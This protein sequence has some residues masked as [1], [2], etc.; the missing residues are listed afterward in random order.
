MMR[1][2]IHDGDAVGQVLD[3]AEIVGDEKVGEVELRAQV[4][5]QV[6]DLRLDRH[7][8]RCDRFVA[9]QHVGLHRERAGDADAL[10]L[11]A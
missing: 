6:Q 11:T 2:E 7:V 8:E 9:D 4:H 1:P 3:D 5:E 10:A